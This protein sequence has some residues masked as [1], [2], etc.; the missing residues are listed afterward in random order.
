[1]IRFATRTTQALLDL[2]VLSL[3]LWMAFW[4]RFELELPYQMFKRVMFAWPYV[5]GFEYLLLVSLGVI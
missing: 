1:M 2:T 5:V 3:A 4:L